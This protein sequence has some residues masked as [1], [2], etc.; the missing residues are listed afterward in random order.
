[1]AEAPGW[2]AVPTTA[3]AQIGANAAWLGQE[4]VS[5]LMVT[6]P[7]DV[8]VTVTRNGT[9]SPAFVAVSLLA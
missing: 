4:S 3:V 5:D 7:D 6:D 9:F 8:F 1:V 2:S